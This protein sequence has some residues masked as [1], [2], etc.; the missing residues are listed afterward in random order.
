VKIIKYTWFFTP[1][2]HITSGVNDRKGRCCADC[3]RTVIQHPHPRGMTGKLSSAGGSWRL[4]NYV[5]VQNSSDHMYRVSGF[6]FERLPSPSSQHFTSTSFVYIHEFEEL[7]R[8]EFLN[9]NTRLH[10]ALSYS[11]RQQIRYYLNNLVNVVGSL[12]QQNR[13]EKWLTYIEYRIS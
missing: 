13:T 8:R 1:T 10:A 12:P 3:G 11:R 2:G 4:T 9:D 6:L 7:Y 5:H